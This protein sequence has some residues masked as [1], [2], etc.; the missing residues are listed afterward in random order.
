[1]RLRHVAPLLVVLALV[2]GACGGDDAQD[3][4]A[5][6]TTTAAARA[7]AMALDLVEC[8]QFGTNTGVDADVAGRYLSADQELF[9]DEEGQARFTL[10]AKDCTDIVVDGESQGP[11]HFNTAW[12][13]VTGPEETR[14]FPDHPDHLVIPTDYFHPVL[15]QTDNDG[16]A[17]LTA[18][19]GIPMTRADTMTFDPPE[20]GIQTGS[21]TDTE[22]DPPLAYRWS[23]DNVVENDQP[24]AVVHVLLG[25]DDE[26]AALTYDIACPTE[27]PSFFG[28]IGTL[29]IEPGSAFE[30]LLGSGF[31]GVAN[32]PDINCDVQITRG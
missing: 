16:Y 19:F 2:A 26:G 28:N 30:D 3:D 22:I 13:R 10:I 27:P 8:H 29:E 17:E 15:F 20:P 6:T 31:S 24:V 5:A 32:G 4:D 25:E 18:G 21:V 1:M 14:E 9:L 23:V 11:G 7:D 12:I